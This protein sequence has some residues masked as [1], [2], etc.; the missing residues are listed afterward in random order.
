VRNTLEGGRRGGY[1]TALGAALANTTIAIACGLGLAV[2]V[3][4]W[5]GSLNVIHL[6]GAAFLAWLGCASLSR[7]IRLAD[8]GIRLA[9]DGDAAPPRSYAAA[10][11]G[12]GLGINLLSPVII[13]FYLSVVPTFIPAGASRLYYSGL[14]ATHV[15]L[16][17]LCHSMWATA[18]DLMRRWL[19]APWTRRALQA[20]T[21]LALIALALR[22][23]VGGA[24]P[25][26]AQSQARVPVLAELFTSEGCNSCPPADDLLAFLLD[27][28]PVVGVFVVPLSEHVTYWDHQGWKDPFG[29]QQFTVRQ[30][31]YGRKFNLDS[32]YTPQLVIDGREE[33]VGS[34]RRAIERALRNAA[35]KAKP[36]LKI[37]VTRHATSFSVSASGPGLTAESG[38]ELWFVIAEDHL[39]VDVKRG[40]NANRTLKHSAVVRVLKSAGEAGTAGPIAIAAEPS[41]KKENLHVFALVQA[42][43]YRRIVSGGSPRPPADVVDV[44][45]TTPEQKAQALRAQFERWLDENEPN[46]NARQAAAVR[47]AI[48]VVT[49][50]LYRSTPDRDARARQDAIS[51]KVYCQL[52]G[53]L[54]YSLAHG[55]APSRS[56]KTLR[57]VFEGWYEWV[58]ECGMQ[59]RQ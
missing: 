55:T 48:E 33:Y 25:A 26:H 27:E 31:Q 16:A 32:I 59:Q 6:G 22:V 45:H 5:P 53:D 21:G 12:D 40:E 54:A 51:A 50:D 15:G 8:G 20:G 44:A 19:V 46:L 41:W 34:D 42:N 29:S 35:K 10:Y 7:A 3:S 4:V 11:V 2:L 56:S 52:G 47:E 18:L 39:V 38:A 57:Q 23:L 49:P 17:L 30:Q 58:T 36:D 13:S 9:V 24:P 37:A 1:L 14:A 43:K 28:Q